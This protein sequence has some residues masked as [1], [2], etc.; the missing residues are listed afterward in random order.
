M[1]IHELTPGR[2][3]VPDAVFGGRLKGAYLLDVELITACDISPHVRSLTVASP[4]LIGFEYAPG[5]DIMIEFPEGE[6]TV[7]RRYT[8]R[9]AD[10]TEGTAELEFELHE[11]AGAAARWAAAAKIGSRLD[12]I[13]P[14]GT[15]RLRP[16]AE[17][18]LFVADD[19]AMP[20]AF[21]MLE[22][23]PPGATAAAILVTPH[24]A[25][26]RPGPL[27]PFGTKIIWIGEAEAPEAIAGM[28]PQ[29]GS[30]VYVNGERGL[31]LR[32]VEILTT[33]GTPREDIAS[34]AYW[35]RDRPNAAHGEPAGD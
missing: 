33:S 26:S 6:G 28:A 35:R 11:G 34:K 12:A 5:Q 29:S 14:R 19:S 10:P 1:T 18:H 30:A 9:R 24:G 4:D 20:A 31:V 21:A 8:I 16:E 27:V 17:G 7:R 32:A 2:R 22:A 3:P 13:G 15:V 23:L 25:G